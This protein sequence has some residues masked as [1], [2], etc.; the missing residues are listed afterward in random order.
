MVCLK[1]LCKQYCC[2]TTLTENGGLVQKG[3]DDGE[4]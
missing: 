1:R 3:W 2:W 4:E